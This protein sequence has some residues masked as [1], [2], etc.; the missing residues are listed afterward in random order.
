L[1]MSG[2]RKDAHK[3]GARSRYNGGVRDDRTNSW[4]DRCSIRRQN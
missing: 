3:D 4:P 1:R 2:V